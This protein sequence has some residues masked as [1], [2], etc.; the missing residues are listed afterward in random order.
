M[1]I[2]IAVLRWLDKSPLGFAIRFLLAIS[3]GAL[4][5]ALLAAYLAPSASLVVGFIA[6]VTTS[7]APGWIV[8]RW[9]RKQDAK[10]YN[11][12]YPVDWSG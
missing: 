5:G 1:K 8:W 4:L 11:A 12:R 10:A 6:G 3:V 9:D 2:V 7:I